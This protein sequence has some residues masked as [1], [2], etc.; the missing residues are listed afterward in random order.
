MLRLAP[1]V[2]RSKPFRALR[3]SPLLEGPPK[4]LRSF[5][6][7]QSVFALSSAN[8]PEM[9]RVSDAPAGTNTATS[10]L[11]ELARTIPPSPRRPMNSVPSAVDVRLSGNARRPGSEIDCALA[12]AACD[13]TAEE[14]MATA[15]ATRATHR[16]NLKLEATTVDASVYDTVGFL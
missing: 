6:H 8:T 3:L 4:A 10:P 5:E 9:D 14:S 13:D 1:P 12:I 11:R 15:I 16:F 7:A 2:R